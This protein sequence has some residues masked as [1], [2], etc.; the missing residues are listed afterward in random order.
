MLTKNKTFIEHDFSKQDLKS[1]QFTQCNFYRCNFDRSDLT[2]VKFIE[3]N[4][5]EQGVEGG[6]Q[7]NYVN[8][9]DAS[10]KGCRLSMSSFIGSNC[11][12]IEFRQCD[13]KGADFTKVSF[14]NK[15]SRQVYFCSAFITGCNLSYANFSGVRIEECDLFEN[16]WIGANLQGASLSKSDLSRCEFSEDAWEQFQ[17]KGCDLTN[18][19]LNGLDLRRVKLDG[20][21]ICDWQQDQLLE[22]LGIIVLPS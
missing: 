17:M 7:F 19:D 8:L 18:V 14:E 16:R 22:Y 21:K 1:K 6:C 20:A 3:C 5:I 15:I 2:D 11:L 13:L 9:L 10:F 12:G 4:F